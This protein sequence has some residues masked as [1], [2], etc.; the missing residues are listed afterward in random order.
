MTIGGS[1]RALQ[2]GYIERVL[3]APQY[4][5][6]ADYPSQGTADDK[7]SQSRS[8]WRAAPKGLTKQRRH[9]APWRRCDA[10]NGLREGGRLRP[11]RWGSGLYDVADQA[12]HAKPEAAARDQKEGRRAPI[13][14]LLASLGFLERLVELILQLRGW[15]RQGRR[16][17][18]GEADHSLF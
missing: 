16:I 17:G 5:E 6:G 1:R 11:R 7:I 13:A 2:C 12:R 18:V 3:A 4:T 8:H 9:E 14:P 15:G 10:A